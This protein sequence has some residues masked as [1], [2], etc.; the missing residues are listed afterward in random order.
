MLYFF[1]GTTPRFGL[2]FKSGYRT[3]QTQRKSSRTGWLF[4]IFGFT[5]RQCLWVAT[6]QNN[7]PRHEKDE[8]NLITIFTVPCAN[9]QRNINFSKFTLRFM[10]ASVQW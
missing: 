2:A 10:L 3:S 6:L 1:S 5:W 7:Y 4:K 9:T 8:F